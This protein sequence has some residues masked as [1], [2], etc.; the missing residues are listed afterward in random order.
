MKLFALLPL[1]VLTLLQG[2]LTTHLETCHCDQ[3]SQL[4][5][6]TVQEA[7]TGLENRLNLVIRSAVNNLNSTDD[8]TLENLENRLSAT[9]ERLIKPIQQQ[10]DYHLP[11]QPEIGTSPDHPGTS[12]N[13]ILEKYPHAPSGYYWISKSGSASPVRVYCS[14]NL[15]CGCQTGG[16]MRVA[17]IDMKNTS[18]N[19]PSGLSLISLPKRACDVTSNGCVSNTFSVQ[20]VQY[21]HVCGRIVG[22]QWRN[23]HGIY[24]SSRGIDGAYVCG[25]SLTHSQNPRQH[26]W[27][28]VGALDETVSGYTGYKCSCINPALSSSSSYVPSFVGNDYFCD[29]ALSAHFGTYPFVLHPHDPLWDGKGCG[30]S[31]SCCSFNT[32]PW[33]VKDLP[34]PTTDNIEMRVCKTNSDGSTPI[35]M[36]E[37]YVQ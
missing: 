35:E 22:Y 18:H 20:E 4:V 1:L 26:I 33:F 3:I 12:C 7:V 31:N 29:T 15:T 11:L 30:P 28:F 17:D 9:M 14:M 5:N 25:V 21:S 6:S 36:V 19:C 8:T 37:L 16:W 27:T 2:A 32:P 10:L 24:Y 34:S 13:G 23:L